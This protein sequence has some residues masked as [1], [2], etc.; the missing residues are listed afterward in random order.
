VAT[1]STASSQTYPEALLRIG[2]FTDWLEFRIGQNVLTEGHTISGVTSKMTA[3]QDLYLGVKLAVTESKRYVP[4]I[5]LIPQTMV[6]TGNRA[7]TGGRVL[8]G[9]NVDCNWEIV[10]ARHNVELVI[11][12]NRV[13]DDA[14]H[15]HMEVLTGITSVVQVN[16]KL[17]GFAEWDASYRT[18]SIEPVVGARHYVVG[19]VVYFVTKNVA[20]D[21]RVGAGLNAQASRLLV[22]TGF[23]FRR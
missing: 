18:G 16:R 22:G 1:P 7:V 14:Q 15:S 12:N 3:R 19:G 2:I 17:E 8:P 20:M 23:A 21:F 5:A 6:P 4:D 11:G 9:L 13:A 10:K